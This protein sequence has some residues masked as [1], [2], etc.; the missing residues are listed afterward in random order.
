MYRKSLTVIPAFVLSAAAM[1]AAAPLAALSPIAI[2]DPDKDQ[3]GL[4]DRTG[5]GL[6][7]LATALGSSDRLAMGDLD[8]DGGYELVLAHFTGAFG[9]GGAQ[10]TM[11]S[12]GGAVLG[13][14][15]TPFGGGDDLAAGD[16]DGDGVDE[17]VVAHAAASSSCDSDVTFFSLAGTKIGGFN[18]GFQAG[19][20][21]GVGDVDGDGDGDVVLALHH[22]LP[23]GGFDVK[24]LAF[25]AKSS[26]PG[27]PCTAGQLI[28][29]SSSAGFQPDSGFAVGDVNGDGRSEML[30][31]NVFGQQMLVQGL[32]LGG[33]QIALTGTFPITFAAGDGLAAGDL[34]GTGLD[35]IVIARRTNQFSF[36][37]VVVLDRTGAQVAQFKAPFGGD[38]GLALGR[39]RRR[40]SDRD[41]LWDHWE[42]SGLD[43]DGDGTADLDLPALG[44]NPNHQDVFVEVDAFDCAVGG[45][46]CAPGDAHSHSPLATALA[47]IVA[48]FAAAPIANPDGLPG[49][50]LNVISDEALPHRANCAFD[51]TCFDAVKAASFGTVAERASANSANILGA[52]R[53]AF[54]YSL[55]VHD[56]EP[57]L[58][59]TSGRAEV[60]GN[61]FTVSLGSWASQ[62]GTNDD[63]AGTF[64]HELGHNLGLDH[65]GNQVLNCK[66]NYFSVMTYVFQV[67]GLQPA[68][69]FDY[70]RAALPTLSESALD[71]TL[72]VQGGAAYAGF[73]LFY[74]P[75]A[76]VNGIDEPITAP[77]GDLTDDQLTAA[78]NGPVDWN[79]NGSAT[80]TAVAADVN[81]LGFGGCGASANETLTGFDDWSNLVLSF[82]T[83]PDFADGVHTSAV[84]ELDFETAEILKGRVFRALQTDLAVT[85]TASPEPVPAGTVL[86]YSIVVANLGKAPATKITLVDTLPASTAF[87][88]CSAAAGGTCGGT[89]NARTVTFPALAPGASVAVTLSATVAP[90]AAKGGVISNTATVTSSTSDTYRANNSATVESTV[91]R[92]DYQPSKP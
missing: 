92:R 20:R 26:I 80:E 23:F 8:G 25:D 4:F 48:A 46:D 44:A 34:T 43:F 88:G 77:D 54:H 49:I 57:A 7:A 6:G 27:A 39:F 11:L 59:S 75:L 50:S 65:G 53:L 1:I 38:A 79:N 78:G 22:P 15:N 89:G 63:Q 13:V 84:K 70:S 72:G 87:L 12:Q 2:V 56:Q 60:P 82:R 73:Q 61:D 16:V 36:D 32:A 74:G 90:A 52:K 14:L 30:I 66:P 35:S 83:A 45:G 55:W 76:D 42:Q 28:G 31:A 37:N 81:D 41:G 69:G 17:I 18:A 40:D 51:N 10:V 33:Q 58:G 19:D 21:L 9:I 86:N 24:L 71:E 47:E 68:G 5:V 85:M 64:M 3:A 62:V 67:V 29:Q 91:E